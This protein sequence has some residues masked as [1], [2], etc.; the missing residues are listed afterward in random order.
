MAILDNQ[1]QCPPMLGAQ[2]TSKTSRF[3]LVSFFSC[4]TEWN[5]HS[6]MSVYDLASFLQSEIENNCSISGA[7][8]LELR[9]GTLCAIFRAVN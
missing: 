2:K 1:F 4:G 6:E 3:V 7:R 8:P 5:D 9:P